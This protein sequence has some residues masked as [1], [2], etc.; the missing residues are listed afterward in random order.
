MVAGALARP[1]SEAQKRAPWA[2]D[3]PASL[4]VD[5]IEFLRPDE[6]VVWLSLEVNGARLPTMNGREGRSVKVNKL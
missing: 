1:L 2:A 4:I 5:D 6:A 3:N